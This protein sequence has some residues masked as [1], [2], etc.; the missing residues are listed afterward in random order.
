MNRIAIHLIIG[1]NLLLLAACGNEPFAV[2]QGLVFTQVSAGGSQ[3][4]ALTSTGAAYC[5]RNSLDTLRTQGTP[6][7]VPGAPVFQSLSTGADH[8]CGVTPGLAAY[9]WGNIDWG[10]NADGQLGTGTSDTI[11][12]PTPVPVTGGLTF[13]AVSAS[14]GH[15]TCGVT[16]GGAAYCWGN[17]AWGQLGVGTSDT[18]PHPMPVPVAGGLIF[19]SVSAGGGHT[20]GVT[21]SGATYC[22]GGNGSGQLGD[23]TT[24]DR[25]TPVRVAGGVVFSSVTAGGGYSCGVTTGGAAYCWGN[26]GAGN[27][28]IGDLTMPHPTPVPVAGGLTFLSVSAG[29]DQTCGL[30]TG[31]A[32]YCWGFNWFDLLGDR[33]STSSRIPAAAM[34]GLVFV[35]VSVGDDHACG[36][37]RAGAVYCWGGYVS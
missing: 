3:T 6:V 26:N 17:N 4:C 13:A 7:P 37:T 31:G 35:A 30:T 15:H 32:A 34:L 36:L 20:C 2:Q 28:G 1:A 11:P 8:V 33:H 23:G 19:Q 25:A 24:T 18:V 22:W 16:P 21:A 12:H 5:W 10:N 29:G 27:L 9:C 14:R